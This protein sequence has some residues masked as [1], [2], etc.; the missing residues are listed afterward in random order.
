MNIPDLIKQFKNRDRRALSRV[1][2]LIENEY[3]GVSDIMREVH[4]LTG[5][6]HRIGITGPPGAGKSTLVNALSQE[7]RRRGKTVGIIAVD[8]TSPFTGGSLLGDRIR[9]SAALTNSDIFMRSM[10]SRGGTGGLAR[11][12]PQAADA[13]DAFG[14]DVVLIETVGVGQLELDVAATVDTT[15]VVLVPETSGN[16]Q[17]MKAGLI[18][19]AEIFVINKADRTGAD[20]LRQELLDAMDLMPPGLR[21][22]WEIPVLKTSAIEET[23]IRELA[24]TLEKHYSYLEEKEIL[25]TNRLNQKK[26]NI[27][28][29]MKYEIENRLWLNKDLKPHLDSLSQQCLDGKIDP[30][31]AA[32][33]FLKHAD[34]NSDI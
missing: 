19:I 27:I 2:S 23:G 3:S 10:A 30:Y 34:N 14:F 24:D 28:N 22:D 4:L 17:A 26:R 6:S 9:M 8:P 11:T 25:K 12:T 15:V 20:N 13:L 33:I 5:K 32:N 7:I 18:E 21:G 29:I 16:V 1:I 31:I